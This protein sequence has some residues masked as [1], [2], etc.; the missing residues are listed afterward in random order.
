[1]NAEPIK[2]LI[3]DD[4]PL[5]CDGITKLLEGER[6]INVIGKACNGQEAIEKAKA[7]SPDVII[8]DI[9]MP[10]MD[11]IEATKI[12]TSM[13]PS[14]KIIA[15][16][17]YEDEALLLQMIQAGAVGYILKDITLENLVRAIK[18]CYEGRAMLN[19]KI[20]RKILELMAKGSVD[21]SLEN[22]TPREVEIL[23]EVAKGKSNKEL[24]E[25]FFVSES[26]IKTHIANIFQKLGLHSRAEAIS[27]AV[28][29]G[30][31]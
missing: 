15:F 17:V 20:A 4:H 2:V 28:K 19:P 8:M 11:G 6:D 31:V 22:L 9:K 3:C 25:K 13:K 27:Y 18:N 12:I 1:M 29:K 24:A 7:L 14:T 23:R 10:I 16:S 30:I 5:I 21:S 26:T